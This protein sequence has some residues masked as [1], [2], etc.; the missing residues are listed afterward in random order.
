MSN[1]CRYECVNKGFKFCS[2]KDHDGG[3]CCNMGEKCPKPKNGL[4]SDKSPEAPAFFQ[5]LACPNELECGLEK[6]IKVDS[7][8]AKFLDNNAKYGFNNGDVCSYVIP[9]PI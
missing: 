8:Q 7:T 2:N 5:Y 3:Y 4:C 1:R 9:A 6:V